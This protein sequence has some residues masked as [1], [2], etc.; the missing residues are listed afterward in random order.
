MN[1]IVIETIDS[2]GK[3]KIRVTF[4]TGLSCLLYRGEARGLNLS[5]GGV[6]SQSDYDYM[7]KEVIGKRAKRRAMHLLEQMDRTEKQLRDKLLG[8]E[9]PESCIDMAIEYVKSYHYIDDERYACNYVRFAQE[10]KSRQ[11]IKQDLMRKGISRDLI[12]FA[13]EEEFE[14]D[15]IAQIQ[16]LLVKKHFQYEEAEQKEFQKIY[17]FLLRRG[18][19]SSDI[20]NTM[21]QN[22]NFHN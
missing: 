8:N 10:K 4:D 20:L 1:D 6:I 7:L 15:E 11:R 17:N 19:H 13:L 22:K 16:E 18:F 5:E 21:K 2:V 9:Y 3:G 12:E 14:S